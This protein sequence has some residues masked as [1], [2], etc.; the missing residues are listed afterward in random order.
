MGGVKAEKNKER[1]KDRGLRG[2]G[3]ETRR[4]AEWGK[5]GRSGGGGGERRER[6]RNR[7]G[8]REI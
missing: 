8:G 7:G 1:L 5:E 2:K 3:K 4:R 6:A